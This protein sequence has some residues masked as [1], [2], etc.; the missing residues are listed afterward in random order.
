M[1]LRV[2]IRTPQGLAGT[3]KGIK[4]GILKKIL[5]AR[6]KVLKEVINKDRSEIVWFVEVNP[7][8][9]LGIIRNV[10]MFNTLGTQIMKNK[11]VSRGLKKMA[12]TPEDYD[13]VVDL[14]TNGTSIEIVTGEQQ[15][16]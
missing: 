15:Q 6:A 2:L 11:L 14:I 16:P 5:F 9:Y 8:H 4:A 13:T 12:D 1:Q 10:N 7:R 3:G